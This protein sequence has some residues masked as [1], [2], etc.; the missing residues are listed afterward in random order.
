MSDEQ[1]RIIEK[2]NQ[3]TFKQWRDMKNEFHVHPWQL[4]NIDDLKNDREFGKYFTDLEKLQ[5]ENKALQEKYDNETKKLADKINSYERKNYENTSKQR[6]DKMIEQENL[7]EKMKLFVEKA[8]EKEKANIKDLS[9]DGLKEFIDTKKD[10]FQNVMSIIDVELPDSPPEQNKESKDGGK[11]DDADLT[12][13][14][15][16][17]F[18]AE[19]I[20]FDET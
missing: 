2:T 3:I 4:F 19:D 11:K 8:Y 18:L 20:D 14:E 1:K 5:K 16:N 7:P 6:L 13:A 12:K 17:E 9:D 10:N 15:N